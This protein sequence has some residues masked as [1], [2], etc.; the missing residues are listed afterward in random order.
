MEI[1]GRRQLPVYVD[2][3]DWVG[4]EYYKEEHTKAC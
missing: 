4:N 3:M 1:N 2:D